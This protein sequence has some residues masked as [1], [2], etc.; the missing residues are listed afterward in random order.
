MLRRLFREKSA[1]EADVASPTGSSNHATAT[2]E[3]HMCYA[4]GELITATAAHILISPNTTDGRRFHTDCFKCFKCNL[5]IDPES[6]TFCFSCTKK[7]EGS[8]KQ[9]QHPYHKSCYDK[10]F[11]W[12]CVVCEQTLPINNVSNRFEYLKHPFF[13]NE[14]SFTFKNTMM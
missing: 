1:S 11:G 3:Q 6:Q 2:A 12:K 10:Q 9:A 13:E 7:Q 4:C 8:N 5:P 14:V